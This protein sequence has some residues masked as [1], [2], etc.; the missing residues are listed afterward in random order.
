MKADELEKLKMEFLKMTPQ[1]RASI[2]KAMLEGAV[3]Y[4]RRKKKAAM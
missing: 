4:A 3:R 1:E 2:A